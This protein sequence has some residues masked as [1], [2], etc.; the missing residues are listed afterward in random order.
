M[1]QYTTLAVFLFV[2]IA[3][4]VLTLSFSWLVRH[5]PA[6][7]IQDKATPYECGEAPIGQAWSQYYVRYYL[8]ALVFAVFDVEI[9]FIAPW[10]ILLRNPPAMLTGGFLFLEGLVFITILLVGL[11]YAWRKD[12]L[13]WM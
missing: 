6:R 9:A 12:V 1:H 3:F 13:K 8:F 11:F 2:G 7:Y 10:A 5:K 4:V